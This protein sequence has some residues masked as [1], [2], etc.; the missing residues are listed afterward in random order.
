MKPRI[1]ELLD[2]PFDTLSDA[3]KSEIL[4]DQRSFSVAIADLCK[5]WGWEYAA[6]LRSSPIAIQAGLQIV[7]YNEP[8]GNG[9]NA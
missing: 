7:P 9:G 3:E 4:E 5:E 1:K 2:K 6:V 8:T